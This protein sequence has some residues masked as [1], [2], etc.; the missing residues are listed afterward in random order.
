MG[1]GCI[2]LQK[3][4][5]PK[6]GNL[7]FCAKEYLKIYIEVGTYPEINLTAYSRGFR[8]RLTSY[9]HFIGVGGP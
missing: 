9:D 2:Y 3:D 7:T 1:S 5:H 6:A 4:L 8:E